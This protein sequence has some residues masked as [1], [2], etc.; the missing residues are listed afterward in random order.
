MPNGFDAVHE[1]GQIQL[2][3]NRNSPEDAATQPVRILVA[4]DHILIRAGLRLVLGQDPAFLVVGEARDGLEAVE[5][6]CSLQPDV[7]LMDLSMPN[8]DGLAAMRALKR[9]SPMTRVL[10]LSV[11]E[12]VDKM[13]EAVTAGA[14]G[15]M[16]KTADEAQIRS[17]IRQALAGDM[18]VDQRM[19]RVALRR[20]AP[21]RVAPQPSAAPPDLLTPRE[22]E[23]LTLLVRGHTNPE[24][25]RELIITMH[26][27]KVHVEHI[28]AKLGVSDRTQAAVR[29]IDIG[30]VSPSRP[31]NEALATRQR[32][33]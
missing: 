29:A 18:P 22:Q 2:D 17:A 7:V 8:M 19:L 16:L 27:V 21:G 9:S 30:Y 28:L 10:I 11:H 1:F 14:A 5:L 3:R 20:G 26:T 15:Y 33:G 23:V 4:D 32:S 6:G 31:S 13:L 24:I 12:D 25:A